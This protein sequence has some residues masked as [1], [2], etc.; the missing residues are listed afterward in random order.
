MSFRRLLFSTWQNNLRQGKHPGKGKFIELP[1][2]PVPVLR[3]EDSVPVF[4]SL[5]SGDLTIQLH[6]YVDP[7]YIK[8]LLGKHKGS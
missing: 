3:A 5:S 2:E 1:V 8:A 7:A 4:A 6:H